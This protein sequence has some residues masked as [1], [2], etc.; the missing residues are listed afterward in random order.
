LLTK[1]RHI[2]NHP[3]VREFILEPREMPFFHTMKPQIK[4]ST[5]RPLRMKT[6]LVA[7]AA[8][9]VLAACNSQ[10]PIPQGQPEVRFGRFNISV[11]E[12]AALTQGNTAV[13]RAAITNGFKK[14]PRPVTRP[15]R[16][17]GSASRHHARRR[18]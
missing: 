14:T 11:S 12:E 2:E 4:I 6:A 7:L 8:A 3:K 15:P 1:R 17:H 5:P 9:V 16:S 18:V 13:W 10:D